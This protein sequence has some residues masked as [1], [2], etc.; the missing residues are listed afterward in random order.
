[1]LPMLERALAVGGEEV[2]TMT[3]LANQY[4]LLGRN[5]EAI[6]LYRKVVDQKGGTAAVLS[7]LANSLRVVGELDEAADMLGLA[8]KK[9]PREIWRYFLL[10]RLQVQRGKPQQAREL[11]RQI[12]EI[13]PKNVRASRMLDAN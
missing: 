11:Y 5:S 9:E 6:E 3:M 13:D 12:L 8:I 1:M 2:T 4:R 7:S 10:A